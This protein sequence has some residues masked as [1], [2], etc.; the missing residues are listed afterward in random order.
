MEGKLRA[1]LYYISPIYQHFT[2]VDRNLGLTLLLLSVIGLTMLAAQL[3]RI[4]Q[5]LNGLV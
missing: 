2:P 1:R 3:L 5:I 4:I